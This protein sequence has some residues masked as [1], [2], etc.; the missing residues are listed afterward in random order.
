MLALEPGLKGLD[1]FLQF[2]FAASVARSF[3]GPA[4]V[5]EKGPL[6]L[7]EKARIDLVLLAQLGHRFAFQ[8]VHPKDLNFLLATEVAPFYLTHI[9]VP[10]CRASVRKL[11]PQTGVFN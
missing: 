4:A 1:L 10:F 6:P 7:V 8:Q 11:N 9:T 3:E 5:L 2:G